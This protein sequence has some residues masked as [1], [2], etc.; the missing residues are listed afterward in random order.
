VSSV[1]ELAQPFDMSL[2]AIS[3]HL[4]VLQEAKVITK[5]KDGRVYLCSIQP[6]PLQRAAMWMNS[7]GDVW[8]RQLD[9]LSEYLEKEE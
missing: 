7:Y 9:S 4:R 3:K 1:S 2:P 8:K 5:V 6:E